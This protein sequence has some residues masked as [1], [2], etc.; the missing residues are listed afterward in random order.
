MNILRVCVHAAHRPE[1]VETFKAL[2]EQIGG[3]DIVESRPGKIHEWSYRAWIAALYKS[4]EGYSHILFLNDDITV[5]PDFIDRLRALIAEKPDEVISLSAH[6]WLFAHAW[7]EGHKWVTTRD[8]LIGNAYVF[9]RKKLD[10]FLEWIDARTRE[11]STECTNEDILIDLWGLDTDTLFW[12]PLPGLWS[13]RLD[14]PSCYGNDEHIYRQPIIRW[15]RFPPRSVTKSEPFALGLQYDFLH[16]FL[17][18]HLK[19]GRKNFGKAYKL[20]RQTNPKV[21]PK[22]FPREDLIL[23]LM[24]EAGPKRENF[25]QG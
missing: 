15:D 18:T 11:G 25:R 8:G 1:R 17:V 6:H 14:L 24:L 3:F 19:N 22:G 12:H 2:S 21:P 23:Q 13:H 9:P 7:F 16:W 4:N 5:P 20:D 10:Q